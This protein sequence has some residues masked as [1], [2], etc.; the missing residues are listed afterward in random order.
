MYIVTYDVETVTS[1]GQRRLRRVARICEGYGQRVQ[2]S[3]FE[4]DCNRGDYL[5][6]RTALLETI[7]HDRDN[8][9]IYTVPE[10]AAAKTEQFGRGMVLERD[11]PWI[12]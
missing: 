6:L 2:K 11:D 1:A 10:N 4:V 5:M 8:L 12:L 7:D 3:V 9:R